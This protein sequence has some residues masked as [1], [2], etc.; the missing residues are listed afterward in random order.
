[1]GWNWK[2]ERG[3]YNA[4]MVLCLEVEGTWVIICILQVILHML[5]PACEALASRENETSE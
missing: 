3:V 5:R 2:G 4:R 1:M